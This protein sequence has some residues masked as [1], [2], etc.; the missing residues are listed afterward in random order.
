[1]QTAG[2]WH[3]PTGLV[4]SAFGIEY[5]FIVLVTAAEKRDCHSQRDKQ[6]RWFYL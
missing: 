2:R 6:M 4:L 1:M 3:Y 5:R